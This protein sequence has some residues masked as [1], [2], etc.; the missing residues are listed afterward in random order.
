MA[1]ATFKGGIHPYEGKELSMNAPIKELISHGEMVYPLS[2]GIGAPSQPAVAVGD[3]VLCGQIIAKAGGFVSANI[4]SSCSGTV[5]AI[6]P[7]LTQ[8]GTMAN[9]II[10]DNDEQYETLEGINVPRDY[11]NM[12]KEE[13]LEAVKSAG[14]VGLGGAG[15]PTHVKLAP[16]N[17]DSIDYVIVNAAECEPYI[18]AD[19]R[20][21]LEKSEM[22]VEGLKIMVKLFDNAKG[23]IAIE[24]NKPEAI[25]KLKEMVKDEPKLEVVEMMTKYPQGGERNIINA[26]TG[27]TLNSSMLPADVGCIVDNV[28]TVISVY[29]AVARNYPLMKR[30]VTVTGDAIANPGNFEVRVG[31]N[32][33]QV[34]DAAGGFKV[35]PEKVIAGGPMM[36]F[37]VFSLDVPMTK[38]S[39]SIVAFV[40]DDVA[41]SPVTACIRCGRCVNACP[42]HLVPQLMMKAAM[43]D[44]CARFDELSGTECVECGS[45]AYVCPAKRPLTQAF[46]N[47]RQKTNAWKREKAAKAKAEAEAKAA[48]EAAKAAGTEAK[49]EEK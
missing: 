29:L 40:K 41:A 47:M 22:L 10:I 9:S 28:D 19:Y 15:F 32:M 45:C 21:M 27:R 20:C 37:S 43:D 17:A 5:K 24:E 36:G 31:T 46:K 8:M 39:S 18:T 1:L 42:E 26:I 34:V 48:E 2:Q 49:K 23:V 44:D 7:R 38:T 14:V 11:M 6:A 3:R 35:D 30:I 12:S 16:K 33:Q 25:K 13:I 4:V